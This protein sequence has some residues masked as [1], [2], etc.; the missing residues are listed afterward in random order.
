MDVRLWECIER[1][2][3]G[4]IFEVKKF[5]KFLYRRSFTLVTDHT[6]P[7]TML[8][9]T[10]PIPTLAAACLQRWALL[11]SAY[12]YTV[13]FHR[14]ANMGM[15]MPCH[16]YL[17]WLSTQKC[18]TLLQINTL[19]FIIRLLSWKQQQMKTRIL[20]KIRQYI[21][22]GR[23]GKIDAEFKV[24]FDRQEQLTVE[25]GCVLCSVWVFV[26]LKH[27]K[28]VLEELHAGHPMIEW[29]YWLVFMFGGQGLTKK[30][31]L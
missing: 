12:Q 11:L 10:S 13:H 24:Y 4:I 27:R 9:P 17:C 8:S 26:P 20:A 19:P 30:F 15:L 18:L 21:V 25:E 29:N 3:L 23:L 22:G 14:N 31:N 5:H 2:A 1:E 28:L 7:V 16:V 6:P